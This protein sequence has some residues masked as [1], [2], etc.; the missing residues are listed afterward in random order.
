MKINDKILHIIVSALL[1]IIICFLTRDIYI[2]I[3]VTFA[4]GLVK[5]VTDETDFDFKDLLADIVGI[6]AGI[7]IIKGIL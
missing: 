2:A 1:T 7:L 4:L 5:E 6:L 3:G